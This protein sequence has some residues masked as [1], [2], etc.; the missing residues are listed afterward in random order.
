VVAGSTG[1]LHVLLVQSSQVVVSEPS[2][3]LVLV[4]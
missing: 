3:V 2:V 1:L 4:G